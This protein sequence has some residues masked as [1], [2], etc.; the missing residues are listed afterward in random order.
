M[1][2]SRDLYDLSQLAFSLILPDKAERPKN[3]EKIK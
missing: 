3:V 2:L 1:E